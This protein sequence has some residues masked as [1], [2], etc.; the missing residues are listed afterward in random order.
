MAEL[1]EEPCH[2]SLQGMS[3]NVCE[4]D[5]LKLVWEPLHDHL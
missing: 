2:E 4:K 5:M 3:Q 1:P